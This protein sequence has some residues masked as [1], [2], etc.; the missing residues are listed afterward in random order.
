[1]CQLC[2]AAHPAQAGGDL[3]QSGVGAAREI[4]PHPARIEYLIHDAHLVTMDDALG[5][6]PRGSVHI[7]DGTIVAVGTDISAP[8]AERINGRGMIVLPGLIDTHWHM[9]HTLLRSFSGTTPETGFYPTI[10]R[11]AASMTPDDMYD[12]TRL[13]AAEAIYGGITTVHDW[14]HNIRGAEHAAADVA[15]IADS[16][17]RARWTFG[18]RIDQPDAETIRLDILRSMK[19][20][21]NSHSGSNLIEIGMGW[22]GLFRSEWLPEAVY[23]T[24]FETARELGLPISA[25]IASTAS[26][27]GHIAKHFE[28]GLLGPDVNIVHACGA[29][30][31]EI[32]MIRDS[33]ATVSLTVLSELRGGW[34]VPKLHELRQAG[35]A[36]GLGVD[37]A[38]L[39]GEANLFKVMAI[40]VAMEN[41][42]SQS[43][44]RMIPRDA[45]RLATIGGADVLG[46]A[47]RVGSLTPG[48]RADVIAISTD[49]LNMT[50]LNDPIHA[51]VECARPENVDTVLIDGIVRK[52]HGK[53][54][55][56]D[57]EEV[58]LRARK[59]A[60][61]LRQ[62]AA[63]R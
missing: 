49:A 60:T 8:E 37:T 33:G 19:S 31:D 48:K 18:Q 32:A 57:S 55:T 12:S 41:G 7:R 63:W 21:W 58:M 22:R 50:P 47:N 28:K 15:A 39:V 40:A 1:M 44:F 16:G 17:L 42:I 24:E 26:R 25:H 3:A 10:T 13:A 54:T 30:M 56:M 23:R 9:W 35:V 27:V 11:F 20:D 62:R 51:V 61:D 6:F 46:I 29:N 14:C 34:G 43:E 38:P 52:R 53:L 4:R 45:L 5:D 36:V 2:D 59:S